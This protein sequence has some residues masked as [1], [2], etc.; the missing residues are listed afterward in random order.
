MAETTSRDSLPPELQSATNVLALLRARK[1]GSLELLELLLARIQ[2]LNPTVNAVVALDQE[3]ARRAARAADNLGPNAE[4]PLHGLPMT[5]KDA[6]EA[7]GMTASCGLP[8]LAEHRP[9]RDADAVARLRAAGAIVFG[10][11]N[12]PAGAADH[13]SYNSLYGTTRNPWDLERTPGGS[14]G[15]S[16][17]AL[18]AGFTPL[19]L[20]SDIAGSIRCPAHFCGVYGHK[21]SFG[22][23]PMRGHIPPPPGV[24]TTAP[25]G[26]GGPLAR[27]APDLELALDLLVAPAEFE[28]VAWSVRVPPSR[29]E[30]LEEFRV[31]LWAE[32]PGFSVDARCSAAIRDYAEDLRKLGVEVD[33]LARPELD[34]LESDDVYVAM[35]FGVVS[36]G[37][38]EDV[39]E[40]T[41][42]A[43]EGQPARSYPARIARAVD[44]SYASIL[45]LSERRRGLLRA[46]QAFFRDYDIVLCPVMPTVAFAHDH[47]GD[48]PGHIAQ[49]SRRILVD[50]NPQP[51]L[52]NMQWPGLVTVADLPATV[53]PTGRLVD[54]LPVGVQMVGPY[55]EDRTP[56]RL[57]CLA[58]EALGGFRP[59]PL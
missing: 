33:E 35:L 21:P 20:G 18:A 40:A 50:G 43:G 56:L 4:R 31:A 30:R 14:S 17:A 5:V 55:L 7:V 15:G 59:P 54:G 22:L 34:P 38:P 28:D 45:M 25:M 36:A 53:V 49:Y 46:W 29:K 1:L 10:K 3:A 12:L 47:S 32:Q 13:Q 26:V 57:A 2:R 24:S 9:E 37:L 6:Y 44:P 27:S 52:N 58:E 16:A 48:G 8:E 42:A 23:V 11:T 41:R 19:E 39:L 51:Y